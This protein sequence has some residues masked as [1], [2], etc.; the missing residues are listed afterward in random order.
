MNAIELVVIEQ[1]SDVWQRG[2]S[3][4]VGEGSMLTDQQTICL[5][6]GSSSEH[7]SPIGWSQNSERLSLSCFHS[8]LAGD[9]R[10]S[11]AWGRLG[12]SY[13]CIILPRQLTCLYRANRGR[14]NSVKKPRWSQEAWICSCYCKKTSAPWAEA[15]SKCACR[16]KRA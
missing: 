15:L 14:E 13:F 10:C 4:R 8:V 9:L 12:Y 1:R 11:W 16:N 2:V 6:A 7:S 3:M 5:V